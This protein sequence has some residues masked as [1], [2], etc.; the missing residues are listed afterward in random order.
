MEVKIF[1][2][3]I[4]FCV[5]AGVF[6]SPHYLDNELFYETCMLLMYTKY[7]LTCHSLSVHLPSKLTMNEAAL[8]YLCLV[9][10]VN[11]QESGKNPSASVF[12]L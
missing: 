8:D 12:F 6:F 5:C 3:V 7:L 2:C 4:G 9:A 1:K 10:V 11:D